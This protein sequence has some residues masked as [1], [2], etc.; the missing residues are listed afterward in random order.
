MEIKDI[1]EKLNLIAENVETKDE[2]DAIET[3][4]QALNNLEHIYDEKNDFQGWKEKQITLGD[5][6]K[7][8]E[9]TN[10]VSDDAKVIVYED[11]GMGYGTNNGLCT[12]IYLSE[13][14][15]GNDVIKVWF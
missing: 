2:N 1:I 3:A 5:I 4:I 15:D 14:T 13:D 9:N 11:D 7:L 12:D 8:V 10:G 6:R